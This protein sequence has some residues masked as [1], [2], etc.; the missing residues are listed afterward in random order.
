MKKT[1]SLKMT[2]IAMCMALTVSMLGTSSQAV[3]ASYTKQQKQVLSL[4]NKQR[5]KRKRSKLKLD[6]KLC[7]AANKRA[8]EIAKVF[9]HSRPDG[10]DYFTVLDEYKI[11]YNTCGENIAAGQ[12]SAK[13]VMSSWMDS[14]GHKANILDKSYKKLGVGYY[15][16][17]NSTYVY[18]WVQ[19]FTD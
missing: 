4:V 17:K 12:P 5:T 9:S 19:I 3:A 11:S 10:S 8:K 7:K 15:K 1:L 16:K 6:P 18:Y 13:D 14:P 2:V